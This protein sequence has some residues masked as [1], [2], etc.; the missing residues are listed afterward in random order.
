V[1]RQS[2]KLVKNDE[3]KIWKEGCKK[4]TGSLG[5]KKI[6]KTEL[7]DTHV[8]CDF[9]CILSSAQQ[10]MQDFQQFSLPAHQ[11]SWF[12]HSFSLT[13]L[14]LFFLSCFA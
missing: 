12:F 6:G 5:W 9:Y 11:L 10:F 4:N 14:L 2:I 3:K 7:A 1:H 13:R 8:C